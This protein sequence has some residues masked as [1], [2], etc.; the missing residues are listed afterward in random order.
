MIDWLFGKRVPT[1]HTVPVLWW[2][3]HP[4]WG[5]LAVIAET[6]DVSNKWLMATAID[7]EGDI[8]HVWSKDL[9]R[10]DPKTGAFQDATV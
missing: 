10:V 5:R 7:D 8:V 1:K 4:R 2:G 6:N 3:H 9:R